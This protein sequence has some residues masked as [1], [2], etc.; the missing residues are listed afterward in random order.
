M[1]TP[2]GRSVVNTCGVITGSAGEIAAGAE[3]GGEIIDAGGTTF[4]AYGVPTAGGGTGVGSEKT[5]GACTLPIGA[6]I[7]VAGEIGGNDGATTDPGGGA[8][9]TGAP[10]GGA[11]TTGGNGDAGT[12]GGGAGSPGH[13]KNRSPVG[14]IRGPCQLAQPPIAAKNPI[15]AAAR[16]ALRLFACGD[17]STGLPCRRGEFYPF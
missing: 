17:I 3:A 11:V 15:R 16:I 4:G 8:V 12:T 7:P 9:T 1:G 6:P 10:G 5:G 14:S 2:A 13:M